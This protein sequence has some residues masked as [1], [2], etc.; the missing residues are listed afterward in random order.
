[1]K[2]NRFPVVSNVYGNYS[3]VAQMLGVTS[4]GLAARWAD[5]TEAAGSSSRFSRSDGSVARREIALTDVP[6]LTF[7]EKDAGP[8][9]TAAVVAVKDPESGVI[10]LSYHRMQ[11][12]DDTELRGRLSPS[13]DLF[14]IQ[15]A[16]EEAG[17]ALEVAILNRHR[18]CHQSGERRRDPKW[19]ERA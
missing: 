4:S 11:I 13:G 3:L 1:M 18:S 2:G 19:R 7:C 15:Q 6:H 16:A 8:Y 5:I 14:R 12:I 17:R 10:N 9:L